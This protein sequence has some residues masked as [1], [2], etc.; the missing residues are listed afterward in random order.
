MIIEL[1]ILGLPRW[2]AAYAAGSIAAEGETATAL[3]G[4]KVEVI[5]PDLN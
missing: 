1:A 5:R 4:A 2:L 3:A